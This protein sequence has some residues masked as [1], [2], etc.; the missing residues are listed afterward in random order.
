MI[1]CVA[2]LPCLAWPK[3]LLIELCQYQTFNKKLL[4]IQCSSM[5]QTY[6]HN[7]R[8]CCRLEIVNARIIIYC[9]TVVNTDKHDTANKTACNKKEQ[10][11]WLL[12]LCRLLHV[13]KSSNMFG[14]NSDSFSSR[15][16]SFKT[17]ATEFM[18]LP[19]TLSGSGSLPVTKTK[20]YNYYKLLTRSK[21]RVH[22]ATFQ[23]Q[24]EKI[25][26]K[27]TTIAYC[28]PL[29]LLLLILLLL[30]LLVFL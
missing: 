12:K 10:Q 17:P 1:Y 13:I 14:G 20:M 3:A 24:N 4:L 27:I 18:S 8:A 6:F 28:V 2:Y 19:S 29:W 30:L 15:K 11:Y 5:F 26:K 23:Q 16:Y 9:L 7:H 22:I 21:Y 25:S